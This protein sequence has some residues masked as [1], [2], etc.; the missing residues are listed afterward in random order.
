[1]NDTNR[2]VALLPEPA[3]LNPIQLLQMAVQ[4]GVDT[5]QLKQ[6]MELQREWKAEKA[7]DA[8]H[9]AMNAFRSE[10]I[11][12]VK[13]K[14][15]TFGSGNA[16]AYKHATLAGIVEASVPALSRHGLS[17]RWETKQEGNAITVACVV[18][19][20]L[21]HSA[22]TS[23]TAPPDTSGSKNSIQAIGSTVSYLQR[24]TFMA[25]T[26]L[27]AKDQD[28]D[29]R[30]AEP[31]TTDQATVITDKIK[32]AGAVTKAVLDWIKAES[33][34][35]IPAVDFQKCVDMLDKKIAGKKK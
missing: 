19:H 13:T 17:H 23:L 9:A 15:V 11:Q 1:M 34:E 6:L 24:Y 21:G 25:I 22:Q 2:Q 26:G 32:E 14:S 10:A 12:I 8:F 28:D 29:G 16:T 3:E 35:K 27:A 30:R 33:V 20:E 5:E 7:R 4:K 31:I 18:T